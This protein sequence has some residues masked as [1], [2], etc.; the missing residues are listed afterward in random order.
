MRISTIVRNT[1]PRSG[2]TLTELMAAIAILGLL[3]ALALP[4]TESVLTSG[5]RAACHVNRA[6]VEV[7][8]ILWRRLKGTWP[9]TNLADIGID[10]DFFPEGIPTCPVDESS[11]TIDSDGKVTGHDH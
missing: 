11:Y 3:A 9:A 6:E 2:F 7:Q 8:A 1:T 5:R 10:T 4:R